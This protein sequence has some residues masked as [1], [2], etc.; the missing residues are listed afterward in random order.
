MLAQPGPAT[1]ARKWRESNRPATANFCRAG[2]APSRV[3]GLSRLMRLQE[4]TP[5]LLGLSLRPRLLR[6]GCRPNPA[7][8]H[9]STHPPRAQ[10]P[11]LVGGR[12]REAACWVGRGVRRVRR[13]VRGS[14]RCWGEA[15]RAR[16]RGL[17]WPPRGLGTSKLPVSPSVPCFFRLSTSSGTKSLFLFYMNVQQGGHKMGYECVCA[18]E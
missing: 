9:P 14:S 4:E 6:A 2:L 16:G 8:P 7:S 5:G 10:R 17:T 15:G 1:S 3:R 11:D 13:G 12:G 18:G